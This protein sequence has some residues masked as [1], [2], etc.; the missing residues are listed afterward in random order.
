MESDWGEMSGGSKLGGIT[1]WV[2]EQLSADFERE[3][4]GGKTSSGRQSAH[5]PPRAVEK[6]WARASPVPTQSYMSVWNKKQV[7]EPVTRM[8]PTSFIFPPFSNECEQ[9]CWIVAKIGEGRRK[10]FKF[11]VGKFICKAGGK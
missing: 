8:P 4:K 1:P 6:G 9:V 11:K 10:K 5:K 7:V 2:D 3:S